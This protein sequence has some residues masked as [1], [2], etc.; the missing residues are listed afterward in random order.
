MFTYNITDLISYCGT[1]GMVTTYEDTMTW[2]I[3]KQ[4]S[5]S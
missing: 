1:I 3:S 4:Q 5:I 2:L